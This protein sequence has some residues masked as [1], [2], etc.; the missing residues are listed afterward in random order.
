MPE[1]ALSAPDEL[2]HSQ[3]DK[4]PNLDREGTA[5]VRCIA[6]EIKRTVLNKHPRLLSHFVPQMVVR[7]AV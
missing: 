3:P 7:S 5:H 6:Q 4:V 2:A 1:G